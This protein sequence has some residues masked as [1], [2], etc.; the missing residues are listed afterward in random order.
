[1]KLLKVLLFVLLFFTSIKGQA[2]IGG[3]F[4]IS[5]NSSY[6]R[7]KIISDEEKT[8]ALEKAYRNESS[9]T[10]TIPSS[11]EYDG[12]TY[13]VIEIGEQACETNPSLK[14]VK[15][16]D[17]VIKIGR[18]AFIAC[19]NL[20]DVI[21]SESLT[22]IEQNAFTNCSKL[23]SI[24]IPNSVKIIEY[25]AFQ[26]CKS[27]KNI[28]I[29]SGIESLGDRCFSDLGTINSVLFLGHINYKDNVFE[30][31]QTHKCASPKSM[32]KTLNS[33]T[34]GL[35]FEYT[36]ENIIEN[37]IIY[38]KDKT[39]VIF[40]ST[41]LEEA[42]IPETVTSINDKAFY[43]CN[44]LVSVN[45][46]KNNITNIGV[47]AF[48]EC[49]SL[50]KFGY[51]QSIMK[52]EEKAFYNCSSLIDIT[53]P[54]N[55]EYIGEKA[56]QK[57]SAL[58]KIIL[59]NNLSYLGK[60]AFMECENMTQIELPE[61]LDT[62]NEE[63]FAMCGSLV[64]LII[65][66]NIKNIESRA[67]YF[68]TSLI[69]LFIGSSL[70]SIAP[71]AFNG[72]QTLRSIEINTNN[73]TYCSMNGMIMDKLQSTLI[74]YPSAGLDVKLPDGIKVIAPYALAECNEINSLYLPSNL[75]TI[76]EY[77]F[78]NSTFKTINE[79]VCYSKVPPELGKNSFSHLDYFY[80]E[81]GHYY[82]SYIIP[83]E[84]NVYVPLESLQLYKE[85]TQWQ[86]WRNH[87]FPLG[88]SNAS[89][90]KISNSDP[91]SMMNVYTIDGKFIK[92]IN[93]NNIKDLEPGIYIINGKK[94]LI[95]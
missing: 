59:P 21:F 20:E 73:S 67:F 48:E 61:S 68:C 81:E 88:D 75:E 80:V 41:V 5:D 70:E 49:S 11:V 26:G 8:V 39:Q 93:Q 27:L 57:C 83:M 2:E 84:M 77:A 1:M 82:E 38:N 19:R 91:S 74:A 12:E 28:I 60:R 13:T 42:N 10:L 94:V 95:R 24:V 58:Q 6:F 31:T 46:P 72:C 56:F 17:S 32:G 50:K 23:K 15:I 22:T 54:E 64:Y 29:G 87:I 65:P 53:L 69:S 92:N 45:L 85:S 37:G 66:D 36:S 33:F 16:P 71:Q 35:Y 52:I 47:S 55:L 34:N 78:Y 9:Y 30:F 4:I 40:V 18:S 79:V 90:D 86:Q 25:Q 7:Y 14:S 76:G 89:V 51:P 3:E 43:Y 44:E 63:T 62:L